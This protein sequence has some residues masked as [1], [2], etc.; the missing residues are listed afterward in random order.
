MGTVDMELGEA[1]FL[2]ICSLERCV[3]AVRMGRQVGCSV[4]PLFC[5]DLTTAL[6]PR[7]S[8]SLGTMSDEHLS[9][10]SI[11]DAAADKFGTGQ[12]SALEA[13]A[14]DSSSVARPDG[15]DDQEDNAASL[16]KLRFPSLPPQIESLELPS[17]VF[18][19][20][21]TDL[22]APLSRSSGSPPPLSSGGS[23]LNTP[24]LRTTS[25]LS[26][27]HAERTR[28][29]TLY[30]SNP[31]SLKD[32]RIRRPGREEEVLVSPYPDCE[33]ELSADS[34]AIWT[35]KEVD[36]VT[37]FLN[38]RGYTV[39]PDVDFKVRFPTRMSQS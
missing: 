36:D 27:N 29:P 21:F 19:S 25:R 39:L 37:T 26:I 11:N 13:N 31:R 28:Q 15:A 32:E 12:P 35:A 2:L 4:S 20:S 5:S 38:E 10:L 33:L 17:P 9:R 14:A 18:A 7:L 34:P 24:R 3:Y 6:P 1:V 16:P 23:G 30:F 8:L 22:L